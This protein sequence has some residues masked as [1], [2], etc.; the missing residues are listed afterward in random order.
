M[1]GKK[2]WTKG[3]REKKISNAVFLSSNQV[4]KMKNDMKKMKVIT[5]GNLV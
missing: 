3:K 2:K 5:V 4:K 1:K